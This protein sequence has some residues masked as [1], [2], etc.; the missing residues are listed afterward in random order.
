MNDQPYTSS[1]PV[2]VTG[3]TGEIGSSVVRGLLARGVRVRA[4]ARDVGR[5]AYLADAGAEIVAGDLA[6][7]PTLEAALD[8]VERAFLLSPSAP[9]QVELQSAFVRVAKQ[10]GV[11]HLV[12]LSGAHAN[13]D[14]AARFARWHGQV[15]RA[16]VAADLPHTF[17]QPVYFM[18]NVPS[19][20]RSAGG[21]FFTPV[22]ADLPVSLVDVRDV[23]AVAVAALT[24]A[25]RLGQTYIVTGRGVDLARA[26]RSHRLRSD[27][28]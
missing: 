8:R 12:K 17:V 24:A 25:R 15:E 5:A 23:A 28:C 18:Q 2:L 7:P 19:Q 16:I 1:S 10:A 22:P 11:R 27:R 20:I 26:D 9:D 14:A 21:R 13:P 4:L 3:A 6:L